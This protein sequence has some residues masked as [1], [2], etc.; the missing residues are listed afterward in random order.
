L[1]SQT[2]TQTDA[3]ENIPALHSTADEQVCDEFSVS[4]DALKGKCYVVSNDFLL[5]CAVV[6]AT[7]W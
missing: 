4:N 2:V 5:T 6:Y 3:G 1:H 7:Q